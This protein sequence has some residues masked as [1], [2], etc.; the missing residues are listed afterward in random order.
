LKHRNPLA[1]LNRLL[2]AMATRPENRT[3]SRRRLSQPGSRDVKRGREF[4]KKGRHALHDETDVVDLAALW[5][6]DPSR[7]SEQDHLLG[8][9]LAA[10][11]PEN[12]S[13]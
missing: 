10:R 4:C 6:I 1:R 13:Q 11:L 9:G 5:S 3:Q 12:L 7:L 8:L 2:H